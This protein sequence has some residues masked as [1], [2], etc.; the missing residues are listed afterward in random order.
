MEPQQEPSPPPPPSQPEAAVDLSLSLAPAGHRAHQLVD[1][2]SPTAFIDGKK[3]RL[4]P[5][6]YCH[7]KFLK[8]QALG[9]HQNAHKKDRAAAG[10]NPHIYGPGD[11]A[12]TSSSSAAMSV[13]IASHGGLRLTADRPADII[14]LERPAGGAPLLAAAEPCASRR[15]D[16]ADMLNWRRTSRTAESAGTATATAASSTGSVLVPRSAGIRCLVYISSQLVYMWILTALLP[17]SHH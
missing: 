13:P 5:C 7:K 14:K 16:T 3:V 17:Q 10:W 4:F 11:G 6:L 15:D 1:V 12:A 8:S 9:G 2:L